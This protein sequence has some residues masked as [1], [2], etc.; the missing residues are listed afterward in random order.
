VDNTDPPLLLDESSTDHNRTRPDIDQPSPYPRELGDREGVSS[1]QTRPN[2][3]GFA[4][5]SPVS[6]G[7][8]LLNDLGVRWFVVGTN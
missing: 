3:L 1:K 2:E 7:W 6:H 5:L 4:N 8:P